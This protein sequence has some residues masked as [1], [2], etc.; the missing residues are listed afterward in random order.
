MPTEHI[1]LPKTTQGKQKVLRKDLLVNR[2]LNCGDMTLFKN[3]SFDRRRTYFYIA[4]TTRN[5]TESVN[6]ESAL[7]VNLS[8]WH[9]TIDLV[10]QKI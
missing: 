5:L 8:M 6:L 2:L 1:L 10:R 9:W 7:N 3:D 4:K